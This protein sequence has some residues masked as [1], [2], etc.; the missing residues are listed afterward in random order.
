MFEVTQ[1]T[2]G[3]I[4]K[5]DPRGGDIRTGDRQKKIFDIV[6]HAT[7]LDF[8]T[9]IDLGCGTGWFL[10]LWLKEYTASAGD[11]Y[12]FDAWEPQ[13]ELN[14][15]RVPS[16]NW[17]LG[18][19]SKF[20]NEIDGLFGRTCTLIELGMNTQYGIEDKD[21]VHYKF[22]QYAQP[23]STVILEAPT[24]YSLHRYLSL[25]QGYLENGFTLK[26]QRD[27]WLSPLKNNCWRRLLAVLTK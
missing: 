21:P 16:G 4:G 12:G 19:V 3:A 13:M 20:S 17:F 5:I 14:K 10:D 25:F 24:H 9:I 2:R 26:V 23:G 27:I 1:D 18:N 22:M 11:Y 6:K 8:A 7:E 15:E